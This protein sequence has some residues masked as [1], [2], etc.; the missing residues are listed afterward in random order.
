VTTYNFME[1]SRTVDELKTTVKIHIPTP[2]VD[3]LSDEV[4]EFFE[5]WV[6]QTADVLVDFVSVFIKT[7][8]GAK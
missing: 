2:I 4:W 5:R 6:Q 3:T 8:E 7:L 1:K